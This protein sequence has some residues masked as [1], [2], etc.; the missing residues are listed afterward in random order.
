MVLGQSWEI[1]GLQTSYIDILRYP[2][3]SMKNINKTLIYVKLL[4][5]VPTICI[6]QEPR[7]LNSTGRHSG[8]VRKEQKTGRVSYFH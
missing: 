4:V 1:L 8:V 3:I 6:T 2:Y 5:K 7:G